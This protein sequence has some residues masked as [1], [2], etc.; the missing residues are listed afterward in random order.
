[1]SKLEQ[2]DPESDPPRSEERLRVI[3]DYADDLKRDLEDRL[4]KLLETVH[5]L[6]PG[7]ER[8]E[9][10]KEIGRF[11]IKMDAILARREHQQSGK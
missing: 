8:H 5:R 10:L 7:P 6:P 3:K 1:M 4:A 2:Q 9:F 11:R